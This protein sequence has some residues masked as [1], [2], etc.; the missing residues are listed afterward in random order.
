MKFET[1]WHHQ[2]AKKQMAIVNREFFVMEQ[3]CD[4]VLTLVLAPDV[5]AVRDYL[6]TIEEPQDAEWIIK[7]NVGGRVS[8]TVRVP[9]PSKGSQETA[10]AVLRDLPRIAR[11]D[12]GDIV[13]DVSGRIYQY[14]ADSPEFGYFTNP[15]LDEEGEPLDDNALTVE[16]VKYIRQLRLLDFGTI[17]STINA[18]NCVAGVDVSD[19]E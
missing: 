15:L 2:P 1:Y 13:V 16:H 6:A 11:L 12:H 10:L 17:I 9:A 3:V 14:D 8:Q 5:F 18:R 4:G 7:A 19:S